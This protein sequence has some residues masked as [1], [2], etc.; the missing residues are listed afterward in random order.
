MI[1]VSEIEKINMGELLLG[2]SG[3]NYP[4]N[5]IPHV[6]DW[7]NQGS[8]MTDSYISYNLALSYGRRR[9]ARITRIPIASPSGC[10]IRSSKFF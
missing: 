1:R 2:C 8:S 6:K 4:D 3:W 9:N 7:I 10:E 5:P